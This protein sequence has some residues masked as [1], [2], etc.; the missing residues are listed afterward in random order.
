MAILKQVIGM[1]K[2]K[3]KTDPDIRV[4]VNISGQSIQSEMFFDKMIGLLTK[5]NRRVVIYFLKSQKVQ[6]C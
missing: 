1:I 4:A 3:Q 5:T 2:E 6:D